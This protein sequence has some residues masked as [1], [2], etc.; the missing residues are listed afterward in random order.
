MYVKVKI[1]ESHEFK[2]TI[3]KR[4][5]QELHEILKEEY[6]DIVKNKIEKVLKDN[7][8]TEIN[9]IGNK[10]QVWGRSFVESRIKDVISINKYSNYLSDRQIDR[11]IKNFIDKRMNEKFDKLF[12][13]KY[14]NR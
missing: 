1:N 2:E 8:N 9:D 4:I 7:W 11:Y 14:K 12:Q 3:I 5:R 6:S 10:I 13:E